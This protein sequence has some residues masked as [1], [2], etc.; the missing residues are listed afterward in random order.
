MDISRSENFGF[1]M[2]FGLIVS[3]QLI[4]LLNVS[5]EDERVPRIHCV[6]SGSN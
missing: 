5:V 4:H 6:N 3:L 1:W 2:I